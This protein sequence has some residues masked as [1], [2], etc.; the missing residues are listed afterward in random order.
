MPGC[1]R[2]ELLGYNVAGVTYTWTVPSGWSI[3]TGQ[4]TNSITVTAGSS[5]GNI[6]VTPSNTCGNGTANSYAV[7][8][9]TVPAQ[10]SGISGNNNPC[11]GTT[12]LIYT[13]TNVSG[14]TYTWS[15]PSGWTIT[16]GQGS[17]SITATAGTSS[18]N[19]T[20]T[21]SNDCGNGTTNSLAVNTQSVP[22]TPIAGT[23]VPS[24]TQI[25]WNWNTA[26][27]ATGYK[28]NTVNNYAT[29][30][31]NGTSTTY[32]QTGL[33]CNT[34]YTLYVW[35]YNGCGNS[36]VLQLSQTTSACASG[37]GTVTFTY[38]GSS[39]TYGT[40][41]SA[42]NRCW[43]DRNL[44]AT[45]VATSS[46]DEDAYGDLF[47]WGRLDDGHQEKTSPTTSTLSI[48]DVPG[49][50]NFI[51]VQN[52][53]YDWRSPQNN[54]LWQGV[55]STNNPCPDGYRLPTYTEWELERMSW[56]TNNADGAFASPLKLTI[57]GLRNYLAGLVLGEGSSGYYWSSSVVDI[58][59][60]AINLVIIM[61]L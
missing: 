60:W 43:L 57:A 21:P 1:N 13:V 56:N 23:H 37:C 25:V 28:Y 61:L 51:T 4:G 17:N 55:N 29:A 30:I 59:A 12:G 44:G 8:T 42:N 14:V 18:G 31:D 53:P 10:P 33:T 32:T 36:S 52:Y 47:Q 54:N 45:Q 26:A 20:V 3:T 39:V 41:T 15:V 7:T 6:T 49:H 24:Q 19:I 16:A 5:S 46:T 40:V 22:A 34:A 50:G 27:G 48:S 35:A 38:N 11:Q 9:H 2:T 58:K